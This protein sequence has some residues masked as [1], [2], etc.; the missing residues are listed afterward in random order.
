VVNYLL[1]RVTG[2]AAGGQPPG[3]RWST[4]GKNLKVAGSGAGPVDGAVDAAN[5][6]FPVADHVRHTGGPGHGIDRRVGDDGLTLP[7]ASV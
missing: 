6:F 7:G 3:V 4:R 1:V 2:A 5:S